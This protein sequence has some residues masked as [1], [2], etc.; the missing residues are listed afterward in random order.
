MAIRDR[1]VCIRRTDFSETSLVV[2]VLTR[3][4]GVVSLMAKGVKRPKSRFGGSIDLLTVADAVF[5]LPRSHSVSTLGTLMAWDLAGYYP[6]LHEDLL[7]NTTAT[8]ACE[9]IGRLFEELDPHPRSFDATV[10]LLEALQDDQPP[11]RRFADFGRELLIDIGLTPAWGRC[12]ACRADVRAVRDPL[13]FTGP[14]SGVLCPQCGPAPGESWVSV[15]A[16]L[17][18]FFAAGTPPTGKLAL[19]ITRWLIYHVQNQTGRELRA[20]PALERA[21]DAALAELKAKQ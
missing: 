12:A 1:A 14:R 20:A 15:S 2:R 16:S 11:L 17:R 10:A 6:R 13:R 18:D 8:L 3:G 7:R 5:S 9:L 21:I 4:H 19:E